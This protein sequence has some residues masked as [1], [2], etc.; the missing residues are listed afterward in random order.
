MTARR[1]L[2][3][4]LGVLLTA[5]GAAVVATADPIA[6]PDRPAAT[7]RA[8]S[9]AAVPP[10]AAVPD[11]ATARRELAS[12]LR[13][14]GVSQRGRRRLVPRAEWGLFALRREG[15]GV[16]RIGGP[17]LLP[18]GTAW[19][20]R[21][22]RPLTFVAAIALAELP[23]FPDRGLLPASG[24]LLFFAAMEKLWEP[25][26]GNRPGGPLRVLH[27]P[28]TTPLDRARPPKP[29][30][31]APADASPVGMRSVPL[32]FRPKLT[33]LDSWSARYDRRIGLGPR[34]SRAYDRASLAWDRRWGV[35]PWPK[36]DGFDDE[37]E[38][39]QAAAEL[40]M[41]QILGIPMTSQDDP[42]D[43]DQLSLLTAIPYTVG[44]DF[45]DAGDVS[46]VIA[47]RDLRDGRWSRITVVPSSS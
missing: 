37:S 17:A 7:A 34:D 24:T 3:A 22:G 1:S 25:V 45:L 29:T 5:G 46:F 32:A 39:Q 19:P 36:G 38:A 18:R 31:P 40:S 42:R 2:L 26:S 43:R 20:V 15:P 9:A 35:P 14:H 33:L 11:D 10:P 47:R 30:R 16:S 6:A 28:A 13:R 8:A 27:V 44:G 4:L 23:G 41:N 12:V 21:R